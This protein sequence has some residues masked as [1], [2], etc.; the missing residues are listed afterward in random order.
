MGLLDRVNLATDHDYEQAIKALRAPER[1]S[2]YREVRYPKM[3]QV[4]RDVE[5]LLASPA[6][7]APSMSRA[8]RLVEVV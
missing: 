7:L 5:E 2:G 4:R 3:D 6:Q 8:H 1:V